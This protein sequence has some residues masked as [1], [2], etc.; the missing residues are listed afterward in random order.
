MIQLQRGYLIQNSVNNI[1]LVW[2]RFVIWKNILY[3]VFFLFFRFRLWCLSFNTLF[4]S[5]HQPLFLS[6]RRVHRG[7]LFLQ[8][9][10]KKIFAVR[11][12]HEAKDIFERH[13]SISSILSEKR[14]RLPA[15]FVLNYTLL[16][17]HI[18]PIIGVKVIQ[19]LLQKKPLTCDLTIQDFC[20]LFHTVL[21]ISAVSAWKNKGEKGSLMW[22]KT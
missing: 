4:I 7:H 6:S 10:T 13:F 15:H 19:C 3:I 20:W 8:S 17:E 21:A 11:E 14:S 22:K 2:E 18:H 5:S 9:K 1:P 12:F 16:A